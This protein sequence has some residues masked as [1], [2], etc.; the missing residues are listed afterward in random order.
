MKA[1]STLITALKGFESCRLTAYRCPAGVWTIGYGHTLGVKAG[2][3]ITQQQAD[4]LLRGD[5][6]PT[7]KYIDSLGVCKTQGQFDALVDFAYN[8]GSGSLSRS[9]LLQYIIRGKP[10]ATIQAEFLKWNRSGKN[11]L[12][13]LTK[14]RQWEARRWEE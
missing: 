13:G 2:Q 3:H 1:S 12:N 4:S 8:L 5:L 11:I 7:E 9:T 14:R 6:L 10:T